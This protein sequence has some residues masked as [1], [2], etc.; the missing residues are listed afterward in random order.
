MYMLKFILKQQNLNYYIN[1]IM[2]NT[3]IKIIM[4]ENFEPKNLHAI[5]LFKDRHDTTKLNGNVKS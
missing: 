2:R 5:G 1:K 3:T 4:A